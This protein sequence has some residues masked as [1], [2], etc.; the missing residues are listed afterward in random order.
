MSI[1]GQITIS[2][3]LFFKQLYSKLKLLVYANFNKIKKIIK[4]KN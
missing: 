1:Q 2:F 4:I 3:L